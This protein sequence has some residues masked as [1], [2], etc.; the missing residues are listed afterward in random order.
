MLKPHFREKGLTSYRGILYS[1]S[2]F[3]AFD[4]PTARALLGS[5]A[6]QAEVTRTRETLSAAA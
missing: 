2:T 1:S 6:S 4:V 5:K 3:T